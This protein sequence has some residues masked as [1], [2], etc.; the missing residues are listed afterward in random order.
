MENLLKYSDKNNQEDD[1]LR[2]QV[3]EYA[4]ELSKAS[5]KCKMLENE[6]KAIKKDCENQVAEIKM[7][8][9]AR[10][11]QLREYIKKIQSSN[12]N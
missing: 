12:Q 6:I 5:Q 9:Q 2:R 10:E 7:N 8:F 11:I 4:N 3:I 1:N